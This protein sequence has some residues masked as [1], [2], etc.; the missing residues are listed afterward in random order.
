MQTF[1]AHIKLKL[2]DESFRNMYEEER[3]KAEMAVRQ[4]LNRNNSGKSRKDLAGD[5]SHS[6]CNGD[7]N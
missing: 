2:K 6:Q 7:V 3:R 1:A 5:E 4:T